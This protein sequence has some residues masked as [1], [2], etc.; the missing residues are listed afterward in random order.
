MNIAS[1]RTL[2]QKEWATIDSVEWENI[3]WNTIE[4]RV[5]KLQSQITKAVIRGHKTLVKKLQYLLS[6]SYYAKLLSVRKVTTSSGKK[7][8]G[9]DGELW[10]TS[11]IK[12]LK[13]IQLTTKKYKPSPLRRIYIPK[14]NG[15]LRPIGIPTMYDRAMQALNALQLDPVA[16]ATADKTSFG[17]RKYR[18]TQDAGAYLFNVLGRKSSA[19]WILEGDIK[20]CFDNI[21]HEW[22]MNNV[23][24][25]KRMLRK[26]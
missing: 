13:A 1:Q 21:N 20:G 26:F 5:N 8:P 7:T 4:A 17:F 6:K 15:K 14:N 24:M 25:N 23:M 22:L 3:D 16:E 10:T 2:Q 19:S 18:S 11:K 12:L 9:I